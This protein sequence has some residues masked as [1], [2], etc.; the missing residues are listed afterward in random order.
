MEL[1]V[2]PTAD[3][4]SGFRAV[5]NVVKVMDHV[6]DEGRAVMGV[7]VMAEDEEIDRYYGQKVTWH[8]CSKADCGVAGT[9]H[10]E[11]SRPVTAAQLAAGTHWARLLS[12]RAVR[13][14]KELRAEY[15]EHFPKGGSVIS[16]GGVPSELDVQAAAAGD[17]ADMLDIGRMSIGDLQMLPAGKL[18][19][20]ANRSG[21]SS[22]DHAKILAA[23]GY[24]ADAP[25]ASA[26]ESKTSLQDVLKELTEA[27]VQARRGSK[28][29]DEDSDDSSGDVSL[30][31][32]RGHRMKLL[33][34]HEKYPGL[35]TKRAVKEAG[36][37][38]GAGFAYGNAEKYK[39]M[40]KDLKKIE[41]TDCPA[42][43]RAYARGL[44]LKKNVRSEREA[45]TLATALDS[46]L[47]GN[48]DGAADILTQRLKAVEQAAVDGGV[49]DRAQWF[50]L[51]APTAASLASREEVAG[52]AREQAADRRAW[53]SWTPRA[54]KPAEKEKGGGKGRPWKQQWVPKV[55]PAVPKPE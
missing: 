24:V 47:D 53:S 3:G 5:A 52:A 28:K 41:L 40:M 45:L 55:E 38:T 21:V 16:V 19:N 54:P 1:T 27:L 15:A 4:G 18:C 13:P 14:V 25:G 33:K 36:E 42:L 39:A 51:L 43:F 23:L 7:L 12:S 50:E 11:K 17:V 20:L 26:S 29:D 8:L 2:A 32:G 46:L 35:L 37:L 44:D 34:L 49:W 31:S 6:K 22:T 9:Y 30:S 10:V 48:V